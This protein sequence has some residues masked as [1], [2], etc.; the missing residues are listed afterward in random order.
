MVFL[1]L[2]VVVF[3]VKQH[4]LQVFFCTKNAVLPVVAAVP[5]VLVALVGIVVYIRNASTSNK[6]FRKAR[7]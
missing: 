1:V 4:L 5:C 3:A 2:V 6:T 7:S